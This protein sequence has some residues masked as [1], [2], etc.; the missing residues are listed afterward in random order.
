LC[1]SSALGHAGEGEAV[2]GVDEDG[3][4][5]AFLHACSFFDDS[6]INRIALQTKIFYIKVL[7]AFHNQPH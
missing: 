4:N 3:R 1:A 6:Q 2:G 7:S 5:V